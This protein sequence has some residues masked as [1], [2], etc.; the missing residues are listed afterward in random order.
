M[1]RRRTLSDMRMG[2]DMYERHQAVGTLLGAQLTGSVLDVGGLAGG[3]SRFMPGAHVVALNV[4]GTGDIDYDGSVIPFDDG[5]FDV[6]VSLDTLE[7]VP[8]SG[9]THFMAECLRVARCTLL[10]AAPYG[11]AGHS[12]YEAKLDN[13]YRD[14]YGDYHR[15]LHEHVLNGLPRE[16]DLALYR[17]MVVVAGFAV[18]SYYCGDYGWLCRNLERSLNLH[19]SLGPLRKLSAAYDLLTLAAPWPEPVFAETATPTANRFYL[20]AQKQ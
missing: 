7:H 19:R 4:D 14:V 10:V 13:L 20:L 16:A 1:A 8:P 11:S 17:R 15:W 5:S 9:R 18:K 2:Y 12:A 3:L 6:V